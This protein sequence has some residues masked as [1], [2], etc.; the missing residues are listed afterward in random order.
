MGGPADPD[1]LQAHASQRLPDKVRAKFLGHMVPGSTQVWIINK[2]ENVHTFIH[3]LI[4]H[5]QEKIRVGVLLH[6]AAEACHVAVDGGC[7][8]NVWT[9]GVDGKSEATW[10]AIEMA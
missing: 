4:V 3:L 8:R 6:Q 7:G 2:C 5:S 9:E 10:A 1:V